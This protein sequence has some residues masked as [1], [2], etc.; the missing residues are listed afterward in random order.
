MAFLAQSKKCDLIDL[1]G[2][3]GINVPSKCL[4]IELKKLITE[5]EAYEETFVKNL[6]ERI[7]EDRLEKKLLEERNFE[8]LE[9][10]L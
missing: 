4:V 8:L 10:I 6:L 9:K 7:T 5:S 3:L 2:E 1:A